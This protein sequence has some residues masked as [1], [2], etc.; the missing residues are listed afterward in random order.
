MS[1][2]NQY[3]GFHYKDSQEDSG[4][5]KSGTPKNAPPLFGRKNDGASMCAKRFAAQGKNARAQLPKNR[6]YSNM[7]MARKRQFT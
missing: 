7:S 6:K 1:K 4:A 2:G 3:N 5:K